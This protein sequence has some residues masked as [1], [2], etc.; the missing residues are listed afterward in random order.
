M[1]Y[2]IGE[3]ILVVIGILIALQI[4]NW[5]EGRKDNIKEQ[6]VLEQLEK[7]YKANLAQLQDKMQ[8]RA[9]IVQSGQTLLNYIDAPKLAE[10]DSVIVHI[11]NI[12]LDPTF[13]PVQNDLLSSGNLRLI[14]ND[15][16]RNLLSNWS[17]DLIAVQEAE[18]NNRLQV[19]EIMIPLLNEIG[20]TRDVF[21]AVWI[22]WGKNAYW[23]LDENTIVKSLSLGK[24]TTNINVEEILGNQ[25][26]EG[27]IANAISLNN[28][29][30]IESESLRNRITE[31]L[32]LI[33]TEIN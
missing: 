19:H 12:V 15:R 29:G 22:N 27:V 3:I 2:A 31:I 4:N 10:R 21:N 24:S 7:E 26:L 20:I 6:V 8:M 30:N 28:V 16:L 32:E 18:Q 17:S 33:R 13:D 25:E 14:R 11:S 9:L 5:N 1:L 23:L